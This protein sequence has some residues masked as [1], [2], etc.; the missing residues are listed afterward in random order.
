MFL[1]RALLSI[2]ALC[3]LVLPIAAQTNLNPN[4]GQC[5][6][7]PSAVTDLLVEFKRNLSDLKTTL[8]AGPIPPNILAGL[9]N[10]TLELHDRITYNS[11]T[12]QLLNLILVLP[13]GSPV[14]SPPDT[15]L[16][17]ATFLFIDVSIDHVYL[18]CQPYAA[19]LFVGII[20]DGYPLLGDPTGTSYTFE[21]GYN[22]KTTDP[23]KLFRDIASVSSG[24]GVQYHDY[25]GGSLSLAT[26][27]PPWIT[28]KQ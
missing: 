4:A 24:L 15:D 13:G 9:Q 5:D 3:G 16:K 14:P 26:W 12:N 23:T 17:A 18:T 21:F 7:Q 28:L 1:R 25:A 19:A 2:P 20:R 10:G 11:E 27:G 6:G 8:N 22:T